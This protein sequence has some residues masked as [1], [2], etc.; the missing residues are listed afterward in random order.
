MQSILC[1]KNKSTID[2]QSTSGVYMIPCSCGKQCVGE[3]GATV[4]TRIKQHQKAVFENKK[5]DSALAEHADICNG[6]VQWDKA[7]ILASENKFF[8]RSVRESLEIQRQKTAPGQGLKKD[9]GRY[10]KTNAWLPLLRK[11]I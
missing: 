7:S 3:T 6:S 9:T 10:V 5:N 4:K 1:K 11:I 2:Q 8:R